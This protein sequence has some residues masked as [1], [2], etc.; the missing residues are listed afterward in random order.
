EVAKLSDLWLHPKQG[1]DAALAMAMG[2]VIL[3][4]FF[5]DRSVPYFQDYCRRYTDMPMLVRLRRDGDR[6]VP[7][8]YV[9]Q[10]HLPHAP[11]SARAAWKSVAI[12]TT[13]G[14][15]VVPQGSIGYRWPGAG[16]AKG[17][18]NLEPRDG[19]S[20]A[21]VALTFSLIDRRDDTVSVAFPYFG[22]RPHARF[23]ENDQGSD[24][25]VRNVPVRR[26]NLVDGETL[27]ATVFDLLCAN[28]G[29]D[30]GLGGPCAKDYDDDVPYT[31]R[32]AGIDHRSTGTASDLARA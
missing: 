22:G 7:D 13:T 28:Y 9:R 24:V 25:L 32:L 12:D 5:V 19:E 27:V 11:N 26:V 10:S 20:G 15:L 4:E 8:R 18:W 31:P 1:T 21:E 2:H 23:P 6:Y 17:R 16:E 30:R 14:N 3:R 29:V